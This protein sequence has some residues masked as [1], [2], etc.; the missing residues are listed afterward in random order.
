MS[1]HLSREA[2]AD[3]LWAEYER[4]QREA[5]QH[6]RD[7]DALMVL[8]AKALG[9]EHDREA[10]DCDELDDF[11]PWSPLR[12]FIAARDAMLAVQAEPRPVGDRDLD[13]M[14][15]VLTNTHGAGNV[16]V[17]ALVELRDVRRV[18]LDVDDGLRAA[19]AK[20]ESTTVGW[21]CG[22]CG[23]IAGTIA[24]PDKGVEAGKQHSLT[25]SANPA[26]QA[27]DEAMAE[28]DRLQGEIDRLTLLINTPRTD[29]FFEAVRIEA[30]HQ[31][32]RWG[33]D[34]DAGKRP[35]D[36]ITLFVYLLGK[37][38]KAHYEFDRDK[39]LHHVITV[40]AVALNWHRNATGEHTRM[41][42]GI[43]PEAA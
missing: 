20:P 15:S 19:M 27:R 28:V 23:V 41:R 9:D 3:Q 38:A 12:S 33:V 40:A 11:D 17:Q 10:A 30:A 5:S 1:V 21:R 22:W 7:W 43:G 37:A 34:H 18:L 36:W 8:I 24:A 14:I 39:L 25:C 6:L 26:V 29:D 35:E 4:M 16:T 42:P 31:V 13:N 2:S 32:E